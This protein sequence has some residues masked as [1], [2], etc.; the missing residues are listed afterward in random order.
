MLVVIQFSIST[1]L[2]IGTLIVF[3]Q[4]KFLQNKDLG[5]NKEQVVLFD[6]YG[7]FRN[8][9]VAF[10]HE[11]Q[12]DASVLSVS[13]IGGSIPGA[14]FGIENS[15]IPEEWPRDKQQW[16]GVLNANACGTRS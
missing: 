9:Y 5:F 16:L 6:N 14:Q 11:L 8:Q 1:A 7:G 10:K 15:F 4:I 3:S 12:K 2:I 13:R